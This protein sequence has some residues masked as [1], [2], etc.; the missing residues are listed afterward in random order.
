MRVPLSFPILV[1]SFSFNIRTKPLHPFV[2]PHQA[3][4]WFSDRQKPSSL[5]NHWAVVEVGASLRFKQ[6]LSFNGYRLRN[7]RRVTSTNLFHLSFT[8]I[9]E[10]EKWNKQIWLW[11]IGS[12]LYAYKD[13]GDVDTNTAHAEQNLHG[14]QVPGKFIVFYYSMGTPLSLER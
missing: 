6:H 8:S 14:Y 9:A 2:F 10:K 7:R 5:Q 11:T 4:Y 13:V 12:W 3:T 1:F